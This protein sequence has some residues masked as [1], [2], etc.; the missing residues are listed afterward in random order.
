MNDNEDQENNLQNISNTE[1]L[2]KLS[3]EPIES[4]F[5]SHPTEMEHQLQ[6][7]H[8]LTEK[9]EDLTTLL[10]EPLRPVEP[11]A[12]SIQNNFDE[13]KIKPSNLNFLELLEKNL[14][15]EKNNPQEYQPS[16]KPV[17][18]FTPS[19]NKKN[20]VVSKP[21]KNE[22]KK[23]TYYS[24][25][26]TEPNNKT[27]PSEKKRLAKEKAKELDKI[28]TTKEKKIQERKNTKEN[29]IKETTPPPQFKPSYPYSKPIA[30][31]KLENSIKAL[32]KT[33]SNA[34]Q[35]PSSVS[36]NSKKGE[37]E[38]M[39]NDY[40]DILTSPSPQTIPGL[41]FGGSKG[42]GDNNGNNNISKRNFVVGIQQKEIFSKTDIK[43]TSNINNNHQEM[44]SFQPN[45]TNSNFNTSRDS[46]QNT[47]INFTNSNNSNTNTNNINSV[48]QITKKPSA[49]KQQQ[50]QP[51]IPQRPSTSPIKKSNSSGKFNM[52]TKNKFPSNNNNTNNIIV[53]KN[54]MNDI[55][56]DNYDELS[57]LVIESKHNDSV[58][59][60]LAEL[61]N[62]IQKLKN[63]NV[64]VAKL[65][66]DYEKL[67]MKLQKEKRDFIAKQEQ[68]YLQFET[69]KDE[70][71]KKLVKERKQLA[72]EQKQLADLRNKSQTLNMSSK[73]DKEI[74]EQLKS[75]ITKLQEES[76]TR[77]N[78]NK[79]TIEKLRKQL[80]EANDKINELNALLTKVNV[81]NFNSNQRTS[82]PSLK[83][84]QIQSQIPNQNT[85]KPSSSMTTGQGYFNEHPQLTY[86][87]NNHNNNNNN[88][89]NKR[90]T[91]HT[92]A[93]SN[94][95]NSLEAFNNQLY[96]NNNIKPDDD[97][98][99]YD[100]VFL[101]KYHKSECLLVSTSENN[102]K[103]IKYYDNNKKEIIFT[104]GVRKEIFP[105]GYII[106]YFNNGDLKQVYPNGKSVYYF[107]EAKTVQT[108]YTNKLQVF[109]FETGQ[110]EKHYPDGT[111]L[112]Q[113]PDGS[114]RYILPDGYEET[115]YLDGKV[116]KID[117]NGVITLEHEDGFKEIRYPDG[118]EMR[119]YANN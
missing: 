48:N 75:Q 38:E 29:E 65:K 67:N 104:S 60:K 55:A 100:L 53:F 32:R 17:R 99:N 68:D 61:T 91:S 62:E 69:Y 11:K 50:Q 13:I 84:N 83:Q 116:Q 36:T 107:S 90:F 102:G 10:N 79:Y 72:K 97:D 94:N 63:E 9:E 4:Q 31:Q 2:N 103:T 20:I 33:Y 42:Q 70:E 119:E 12:T 105:D 112:I 37:L 40:N 47:N 45:N 34:P 54:E 49:K 41:Q 3:E 18:K 118:R 39:N 78:S 15:N 113:F 66:E 21:N 24:D 89:N 96:E 19:K 64:K 80:E 56:N 44:R 76:K 115:Y 92:I 108:T 95:K 88:T 8:K 26:F 27:E 52:S 77:D 5:N 110:I 16:N 86:E 106:V 74:I 51:M 87:D 85:H 58:P 57:N 43:G 71:I 28:Y 114:L 81:Q 73:K 98:E 6:T 1:L 25:H 30:S 59:D 101:D 46:K 22:I 7:Q 111:K 82:T 93:H 14:E 109:K 117:K 35:T 23:Y